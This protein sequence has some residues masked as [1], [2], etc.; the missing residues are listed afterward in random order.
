MNKQ[1]LNI[2]HW[3]HFLV[4]V[5]RRREKRR[6]FEETK[7][8]EDKNDE[9]LKAIEDRK[10]IQTKINSNNKIKPSLL[11]SIYRQ[12]VKDG[13]INSDNVKKIFKILEDME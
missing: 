12:E 11:K 8:I 4:R 9:Q 6:T 5:G 3:V 7:S 13:R 2:L 1:N 10:E